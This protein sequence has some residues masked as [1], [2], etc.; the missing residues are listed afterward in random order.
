MKLIGTAVSILLAILALVSAIS[1]GLTATNYLEGMG[2]AGDLRF[3]LSD[4]ELK[5]GDAPEVVI[6]FHL[7]NQSP[8][9]IELEKFHFSLYLNGEFV[10]SNY[11]P[12]T[13]KIL[14]GLEEV[15][16]RFRIPLQ[17]FY[18]QHV[19]RAREEKDF[20]WFLTGRAKLVLPFREDVVWLNLRESWS[21]E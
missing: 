12:F 18:I 15:V 2:A 20:S 16:M 7:E 6:T 13:A 3:E 10:G 9:E 5:E 1:I 11:E 19:E 4:L 14:T 17:P 8:L 21:G